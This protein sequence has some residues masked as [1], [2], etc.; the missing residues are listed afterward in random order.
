VQGPRAQ[1]CLAT[2]KEIEKLGGDPSCIGSMHDQD[3]LT[4]EA[5]DPPC[6]FD[7]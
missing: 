4:H 3:F 2:V 5:Y 7:Q 1:G 6:N